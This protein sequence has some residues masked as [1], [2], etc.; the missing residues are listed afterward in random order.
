HNLV[1]LNGDDMCD[2]MITRDEKNEKSAIDF[3]LVNRLFY[4]KFKRMMIDEQKTMFDLS[5]HCVLRVDF[6]INRRK[7][8]SVQKREIVE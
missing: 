6:E 7:D 8:L 5:D 2:G 1:L 3:I 4:E